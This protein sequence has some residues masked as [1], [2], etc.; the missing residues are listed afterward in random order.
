M[1][2]VKRSMYL[3]LLLVN[4]FYA[5]STRARIWRTQPG[6]KTQVDKSYRAVRVS[7]ALLNQN[8]HTLREQD[9]T[10]RCVLSYGLHE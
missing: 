7:V 9:T 3:P 5:Y 8:D 10:I 6:L 4:Q 1:V 2:V